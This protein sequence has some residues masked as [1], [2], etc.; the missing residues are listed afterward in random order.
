MIHAP[1]P[2]G[3]Q[4]QCSQPLCLVC[5]F[6]LSLPLP[7]THG[8]ARILP[9]HWTWRRRVFACIA[10]GQKRLFAA[11][12]C[13]RTLSLNC[14]LSVWVIIQTWHV[15]M[16]QSWVHRGLSCE[17][18]IGCPILLHFHPN[19]TC[20]KSRKPNAYSFSINRPEAKG[21]RTNNRDIS[22]YTSLLAERHGCYLRN[23]KN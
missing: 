7:I 5:S 11:V 17:F 12:N 1:L 18:A 15:H 8:R 22:T 2:C 4:H 23:D 13:A 16:Q 10:A 3:Q 14:C 9:C 21:V 6:T 19:T 20:E